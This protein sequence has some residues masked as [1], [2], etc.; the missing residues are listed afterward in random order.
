MK[1]KIAKVGVVGSNPIARS[2]QN[3]W[4]AGTSVGEPDSSLTTSQ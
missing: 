4:L 1:P 2:N 3:D